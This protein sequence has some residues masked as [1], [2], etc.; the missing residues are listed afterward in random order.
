MVVSEEAVVFYGSV[1][2][3]DEEGVFLGRRAVVLENCV[4]EAP[5]GFPVVISDYAMVSHGA[6]VHGAVVEE[7]A[8]VGIGAIV[9][10]GARV[11]RGAVVAAGSVVPPGRFIPPNTLAMGSPAKPV[12]QLSQQELEKNRRSVE[13]VVEKACVYKRALA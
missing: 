2:R 11:G 3:G 4:V 1:L 12:R 9:L 6:I 13:R 5:K 8:V 10:D 7:A